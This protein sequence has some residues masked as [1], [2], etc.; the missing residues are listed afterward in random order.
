MATLDPPTVRIALVDDHPALLLGLSSILSENRKYKIVGTGI[1]AEAAAELAKEH[2]PDILLLDLS[3]PGDVFDAIRWI[4]KHVPDTRLIVFTAYAE[5]GL[6]RRA[7]DA[8]ASGF[9]LK[10]RP[11]S[12]LHQAI[13]AV[14]SGM[15]FV[16]PDLEPILRRASGSRSSSS[17]LTARET[18]VLECLLGGMSNKEIGLQL[19]LSEK[20]VKHYM[21]N[22]MSRLGVKNRVEAVLEARRIGLSALHPVGL[23]SKGRQ[24]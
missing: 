5:V 4:R 12:E 19:G 17:E 18:Q 21:T 16:S 1:S 8:G 23:A 10:G 15:T 11:A 6:A 3:M 24:D 20:T 7:M 13:E 9:A 2:E 22:L 14:Q